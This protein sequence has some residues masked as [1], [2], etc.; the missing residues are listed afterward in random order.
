MGR[1]EN[2][3]RERASFGQ[4][5]MEMEMEREREILAV[6]PRK[7]GFFGRLFGAG[8]RER[9][10]DSINFSCRSTPGIKLQTC[11]SSEGRM[12]QRAQR[13]ND[14]FVSNISSNSFA[15]V[16]SVASVT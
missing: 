14:L 15:S 8:Q 1:G 13:C 4:R 12:Y 16:A 2:A 6:K 5:E 7:S 10:A 9:Q 11:R 3:T